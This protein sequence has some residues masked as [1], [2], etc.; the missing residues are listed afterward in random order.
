MLQWILNGTRK[1]G[2]VIRKTVVAT[3]RVDLGLGKVRE[4]PVHRYMQRKRSWD[5]SSSLRC[6]RGWNDGGDLQ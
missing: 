3:G 4:R 5:I 6:S 1:A 2:T